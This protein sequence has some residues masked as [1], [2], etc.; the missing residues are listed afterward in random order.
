M[1]RNRRLMVVDK[2]LAQESYAGRKLRDS[3]RTN[4]TSQREIQMNIPPPL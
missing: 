1:K 4:D 2:S 3:E